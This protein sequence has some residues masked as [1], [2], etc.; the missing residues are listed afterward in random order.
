MPTDNLPVISFETPAEWEE[1]LAVNHAQSNGIWLRMFKKETK[2][3]SVTYAEAL[4]EALCY[5]WI[6]GQKNKYDEKSWLQRFTP[7]RA[8]SIWSKINTQHVER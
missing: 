7:R 5:G 2:I 1:W 3:P 8:K 4:D 6:D